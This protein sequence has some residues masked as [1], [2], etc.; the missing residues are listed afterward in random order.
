[1]KRWLLIPALALLAACGKPPEPPIAQTMLKPWKADV[2]EPQRNTS[3][4]PPWSTPSDKP[5]WKSNSGSTSFKPATA[6]PLRS[7]STF[8]GGRR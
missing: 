2:V 7:V 5:T 6:A 3:Y 1:M 4:R 8:T